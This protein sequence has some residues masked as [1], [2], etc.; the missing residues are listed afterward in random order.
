[1]KDQ[2]NHSQRILIVYATQF[3]STKGVA[4]AIGDIFSAKGNE[5]DISWVKSAPDLDNYDAVIVGS[6]IQYD[7]WLPETVEFVKK[8]QTVLS[9]LPV[10]YFFTCLTLSKRNKDTERKA[11]RYA[12]QLVALAPQVKPVAVGRFA[13]AL[14]YS[15]FSFL[16]K[17][18]ARGIFLFFGVPEGDYREWS[19]IRS[20]ANEMHRK[21]TSQSKA[22]LATTLG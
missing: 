19:I 20:W 10:A 4:E 1:M 22:S 8:N 14:D 9:K 13:G 2:I 7:K 3:G 6:A 15:K 18:F 12:D 16:A 21:L 17:I 11:M 5:V